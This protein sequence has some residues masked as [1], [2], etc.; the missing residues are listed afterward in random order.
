MRIAIIGAGGIGA[1]YGAAFARAGAE[2]TFVARGAHLAA[3]RKTGLRIEGDR[4]ETHIRPVQATDDVAG[5]GAV[6]FALFCVKLWDVDSAGA[7]LQPLI[8][9]QTAVI[10]LQNGI[11][12]AERLIAIL[13]RDA[14]MGGTAFVTGSIVAPGVIRQTGTYQQMTFGEL[15]GR[16]SARGERL[17]ALCAAAGFDGVLS[18]DIMVPVWDKFILL[19]PLSGLNALTRLPLG[20][21]RDD[22]DLCALYEAALRET[23][24]V[25]LAEGVHLPPDS[26]DKKLALMRSMP[27]HHTTSMGN[28]LLR[29]N[30]LELPWFAGKVTELGRRHAT[31]TPANA[32][33]HAALKPYVNGAPT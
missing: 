27:A 25:G 3:M 31:P 5:I 20:K 29:G 6:D 24:A 7:Q 18:T 22:P 32:F 14:V 11:D 4:G 2:V 33:I 9:P 26:I 13:G 23:V 15:D 10:P 17:R 16:I 12:A 19:V 30:R 21:W 1:I 8:G 28:D